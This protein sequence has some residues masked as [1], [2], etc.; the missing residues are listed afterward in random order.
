MENMMKPFWKKYKKSYSKKCWK[1]QKKLILLRNYLKVLNILIKKGR[2]SKNLIK[3][4]KKCYRNIKKPLKMRVLLQQDVIFLWI[5]RVGQPIFNGQVFL[6][7]IL[8]INSL[9]VKVSVLK[10]IRNKAI[11][12][13]KVQMT[14]M[15]GIR[16]IKILKWKIWFA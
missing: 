9:N 1:P 6:T 5:N 14:M 12:T 16:M 8:E 13:L 11:F 2:L 4:S 7:I 10:L 3:F 15:Y